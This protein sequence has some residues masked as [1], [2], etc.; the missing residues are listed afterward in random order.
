MAGI[1]IHIPFC[2]KACHYCNF[3]FSTTKHLM[4]QM[5]NAINKEIILRKNELAETVD[6]V[7]FGGGTPSLLSI[8]DL[9]LIINNLKEHYLIKNNTELTLEAN[10]DDITEEKLIGWKNCGINR[11]SIGIQSF[12][13]EELVWMNR[14]HNATQAINN[15][16]LALQYFNNISVDLIYG[17]PLLTNKQW[18]QNL[19][20]VAALNIPHISCYALTVEEG[21]TLNKMILQGKK[22]NTNA[23]KQAQHFEMLMQWAFENN[24]E[25]YEISNFA[26][27]GFKSKHNSSYWQGKNYVG[28]GPSAH[29]Y[30]GTQRK[31]NIANNALYIKN[32]EQHIV[33]FEEETLTTTQQLNEFLMIA[34]RTNEGIC[35]TDKRWKMINDNFKKEILS[36]AKKWQST[37]HL[38]ISEKNIQLTNKGKFLADGIAADLFQLS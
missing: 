34:L 28:I 32:V 25:H 23:D 15:L 26:K 24:Y 17:T 29:S 16:Q 37:N 21:T 12:N 13:E 2:K 19:Q 5:L 18:L 7:Y 14:A 10:P 36:T 3:H 33:L 1:Y 4:P 30:N 20:T 31:W 8:K 9:Q 11:L 38:L 22:Q 27:H 6:T 35:F